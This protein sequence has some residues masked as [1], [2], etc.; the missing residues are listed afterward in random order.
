MARARSPLLVQ[1]WLQG[2]RLCVQRGVGLDPLGD[3]TQ[4]HGLEGA[5]GEGTEAQGVEEVHVLHLPVGV[6]GGLRVPAVEGVQGLTRAGTDDAVGVWEAPSLRVTDHNVDKVH[7]QVEEVLLAPLQLR[8]EGALDVTCMQLLELLSGRLV[9]DVGGAEDAGIAT[10]LEGLVDGV[11]ETRPEHL[12]PASARSPRA[13]QCA[14][15]RRLNARGHADSRGAG[16]EVQLLGLPL[17][18]GHAH[19]LL[20]EA[21]E[22]RDVAER[23]GPWLAGR[24][25]RLLPPH[26]V[27]L[28][29]SH[30]ARGGRGGP[31]IRDLAARQGHRVQACRQLP[32]CLLP[33]GHDVVLRR[34]RLLGRRLG[35]G[36]HLPQHPALRELKGRGQGR[37][38]L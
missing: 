14:H 7:A 34:R 1:P 4:R 20:R 12:C 10:D 11:V 38:A 5:L 36:W 22:G 15:E 3:L 18:S 28:G 13:L 9:V 33:G 32:L 23:P 21:R 8:P 37:P 30:G 27:H 19:G 25:R 31:G 24:L 16:S 35:H 17:L 6:D 26:E 2:L 29:P